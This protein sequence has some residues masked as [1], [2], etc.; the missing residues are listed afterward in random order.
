MV[1]ENV[2]T[3]RDGQTDRRTDGQTYRPSTVT[4]AAHSRRRFLFVLQTKY[5]NPRCACAPKVQTRTFG[6]NAQRGLQYLVCKSVRLSVCPSLSR[7]RHQLASWKKCPRSRAWYRLKRVIMHAHYHQWAGLTKS[8]SKAL[9]QQTTF[10]LLAKHSK[11]HYACAESIVRMR[12]I[13]KG[14]NQREF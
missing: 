12:T 8:H 11:S 4:L 5:C 13:K 14:R 6:A 7:C 3:D 1:A 2:V 10:H 9:S